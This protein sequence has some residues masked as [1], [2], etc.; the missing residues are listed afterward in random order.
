M[1]A[2]F[3]VFVA[4]T[5]LPAAAGR[6]LVNGGTAILIDSR[7][8]GPLQKAASDLAADF[9]RVFGQRGRVVREPGQSGASMVWIALERGVPPQ[10][11][12]PSG[13]ERLRIQALANPGSGS[14]A[15]QAVV[16]TGSD[17]RGAI[18]AVYKFSQQF[19]GVDPLYYWTDHAAERRSEVEVPDGFSLDAG[20]A[21]HY[22]G[23]FLNDEDLF[24]G[25]KPGWRDETGISLELWDHVFE[26]ILRLKGDMVIPGTWIFP[27]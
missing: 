27:Y 17:L 13:W 15:Q 9:Q 1:K 7:E 5:F 25:W 21:F 18:Y 22:R 10:V 20:P 14:A 11:A 2:S 24:T 26:A 4:M 16:L 8:P 6:V 12:R 3:C 23:W 19:L